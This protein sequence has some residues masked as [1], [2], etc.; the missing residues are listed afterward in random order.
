MYEL[1][2]GAGRIHDL[3][4]EVLT[5]PALE[6]ATASALRMKEREQRLRV[7]PPGQNGLVNEHRHLASDFLTRTARLG[8]AAAGPRWRRTACFGFASLP[9]GAQQYAPRETP[10]RSRPA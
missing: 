9:R 3:V 6:V 5:Q 1:F 10:Y 8:D 7:L 2:D 4:G